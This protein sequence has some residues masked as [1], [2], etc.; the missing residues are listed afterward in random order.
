MYIYMWKYI[1]ICR[2]KIIIINID[3]IKILSHFTEEQTD[4]TGSKEFDI[5]KGYSYVERGK[6]EAFTRRESLR[7][8]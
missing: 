5:R 6:D 7:L 3:R 1:Y 8:Q 4:P 2:T